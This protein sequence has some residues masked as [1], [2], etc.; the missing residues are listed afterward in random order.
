MTVKEELTLDDLA[1]SY[2]LVLFQN[3]AADN[4]P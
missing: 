1:E 4:T 3:D 2:K